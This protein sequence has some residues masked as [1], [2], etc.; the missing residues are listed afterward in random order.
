MNTY[1]E[2]TQKTSSEKDKTTNIPRAMKTNFERSSGFSFD[3]VRVHYNSEKPAQL[4]AHAYTQ[5]SNVYIAP[6]QEKH[7]PHE[8]GH[9]VQQKSDMVEPNGEI[10]GLP[11]NDDQ[12]MEDDADEKADEAEES[13]DSEDEP[14]QAKFKGGGVVQKADSGAVYN[15]SAGLASSIISGLG[16]AGGITSFFYQKNA[17]R[18]HRYI[19]EIEKYADAACDAYEE[20]AA[21]EVIHKSIRDP[22]E[23][24]KAKAEVIKQKIKVK[25]NYDS[26]V[27]KAREM[28][29]IKKNQNVK[30]ALIR[31]QKA[32]QKSMSSEAV[33]N[34]EEYQVIDD[35]EDNDLV[36]VQELENESND[37]ERSNDGEEEEDN[38]L[39]ST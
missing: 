36:K 27:C 25:R 9:V 24:A 14:L 32:Y 39:N 18:K 10:D 6:G 17:D 15:W 37:L 38:L 35:E 21:A 31:S 5:G 30:N 4:R 19:E 13:S 22:G 28:G 7:L 2:R 3:D 20:Q 26:A 16:I 34:K 11:L 1:A 29:N 33:P 23:K 12:A 8:L